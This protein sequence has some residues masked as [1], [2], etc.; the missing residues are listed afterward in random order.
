MGY[1]SESYFHALD[2]GVWR[3]ERERERGARLDGPRPLGVLIRKHAG[4]ER[5]SRPDISSGKVRRNF[6]TLDR[7]LSTNFVKDHVGKS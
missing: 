4:L 2:I 3:G 7:N 1:A 5:L 6:V